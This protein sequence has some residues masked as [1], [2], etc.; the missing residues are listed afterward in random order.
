M[1][2]FA[3]KPV[4]YFQDS[5]G[6]L[7]ASWLD[8][9][10]SWFLAGPRAF[11]VPLFYKLLG[12]DEL[13]IYGQ[14]AISIVCWVVLAVTVAFLLSNLRLKPWAYGS[15]LL[16]SLAAYVVEW[17]NALLS[18]S[19]SLSLMAAV[20]AAW[21]WVVCRPSLATV[22]I[23]LVLSALWAFT[24]DTNA[25]VVAFA[26]PMLAVA[27]LRTERK[28]LPA[29]A[30]AG[31]C[32]I[33]AANLISANVGATDSQR[34]S[35]LAN[36]PPYGFAR[37]AAT[38]ALPA[39]QYNLVS[40]GRWEFPLLN[41]IGMR[42]LPHPDRVRYFA[43]HGMP[44][45]PRLLRMAGENAAGQDGAFYKAP[46]LRGFRD[47]VQDDGQRT[48]VRYLVS[49]PGYVASRLDDVADDALFPRADIARRG[50][51]IQHPD[52]VDRA[53][54]APVNELL[55]G[56]SAAGVVLWLLLLGLALLLA[57]RCVPRRVWAVPIAMI[58]VT[59]PHALI[60]WHGDALE[61]ERHGVPVAI[62]A[63]LGVVLLILFA[64]DSPRR[65]RPSA[66]TP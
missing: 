2:A 46:E 27:V 29:L 37:H 45:T 33:F 52:P 36:K 49:H 23:V 59:L 42:I 48:Y 57:L 17:D 44:V 38:K 61:P 62:M 9:L 28:L 41:V 66:S 51:W 30:L 58:A 21:L 7:E 10:S 65:T 19:L 3:G 43:D 12:S 31:S 64:L 13:R 8:P 63:R 55:F 11:T 14:L 34:A 6:Y 35:V 16:F 39:Q 22:T 18:E 26:I 25:Y 56:E 15:V 53:L 50:V 47:W 5:W 20:I 4:H 60:A 40:H 24:R 32:L 54:P 1:G